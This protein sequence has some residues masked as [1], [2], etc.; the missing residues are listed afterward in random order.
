[1][2]CAVG[3]SEPCSANIVKIRM[4]V[5]GG[6]LQNE[7]QFHHLNQSY[8]LA[9]QSCPDL[10]AYKVCEILTTQIFF[11]VICGLMHIN[12]GLLRMKI[13]ENHCSSYLEYERESVICL[14]LATKEHLKILTD[15]FRNH[16]EITNAT[17]RQLHLYSVRAK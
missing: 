5:P 3:V 9:I 8:T 6:P 15:P 7:E 10:Q 13:Y 4:I 14:W 11:Y 1:M 16:R 2:T 17:K 12:W